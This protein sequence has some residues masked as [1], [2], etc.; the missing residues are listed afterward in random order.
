ML[1][2]IGAVIAV[3]AALELGMPVLGAGAVS[4]GTVTAGCSGATGDTAALVSAIDQADETTGLTT[5]ELVAGCLY[6][7]TGVNND[8][9]GP[10]G[11]PPIANGITIDGNGATI[12]R[13]LSGPDFR[14][15]FVGANPND[16]STKNYVSPGPGTLALNDVTLEGGLAQGGGSDLGG[17]GAGM[18]G[19]IFNQGTVVIDDSTLTD[20]VAQGGN[21]GDTSVGS[22][23]GGIG[24]D[25]SASGDGGGF[26][27]GTFGGGSGGA[28]GPGGTGGGAGFVATENGG[29]GPGAGGGQPTGLGGDGAG[30]GGV[31]GGDGSGGGGNTAGNNGGSFGEGGL[32]GTATEGGGGG[33]VG[34]GGGQGDPNSFGEGGGGFGGGGGAG[35]TSTSTEAGGRGGFGGGGGAGGGGPGGFGG[36][37]GTGGSEE[38]GGGGAGMGGAI[39]NMQGDVTITNSTLTGNAAFAGTGTEQGNGSALG[40]AVFNLN[41]NFT[42]TASTFAANTAFNDGTSIYN[43]VYDAVTART[44]QTTLQDTIVGRG[45][46]IVSISHDIVSVDL[47]SEKPANVSDGGNNL[48]DADADVSHF[49]LVQT[50]AAREDGTITGSPITAGPM[51]GQL[52]DNGGPTNT[53]APAADSP[54]IDAGDSFGLVT[55]QR[56]DPRPVAFA[57]VPD[58]VGGDGADIGAVEVQQA[59]DGQAAPSEACDTLTVTLAGSGAGTVNGTDIDCPS[60][61]SATFAASTTEAL[62]ASPGA[63]STFAGWSGACTGTAECNV[64]MSSDR[65]VTASFNKTRIATTTTTAKA[66]PPAHHPGEAP[67]SVSE[68]K[69]SAS[70]WREQNAAPLPGK[71]AKQPPVGTT[72]SFD[73]NEAAKVTLVFTESASKHT[74]KAGSIGLSAHKDR[75]EVHFTGRLSAKEELKAGAYKVTITAVNAKRERSASRSLSFTIVK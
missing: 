53:M 67:P 16:T 9:Y 6:N 37:N 54:V 39:F 68:F 22:G 58:A 3:A 41:G 56:G 36:G 70:K 47:A 29:S 25:A 21:A 65:A 15:F 33:G 19:A 75:D 61:C 11:L 64:P 44:A 34:G 10:N 24:T 31:F 8:W 71:H 17:G 50:M 40:G 52:A 27:E 28:G 23:G 43:L 48:G 63:G 60:T 18:G 35:G 13:S 42:A 72:F 32:G 73:L 20:N 7:V 1:R 5:I 69:Q 12:S 74:T 62:S 26:G 59:C 45:S 46:G 4:A 14:L 51:L 30:G 38:S 49:D 2:K 66:I 57:G 55:D